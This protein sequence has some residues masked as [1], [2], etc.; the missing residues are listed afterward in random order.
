LSELFLA[1]PFGWLGATS[2]MIPDKTIRKYLVKRGKGHT[3]EYL[4]RK[5]G[6]LM[7]DALK[8]VDAIERVI[9]VKV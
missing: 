3:V 4:Y 7:S 8:Q 5:H 1:Y 6:Y 9:K 2:N